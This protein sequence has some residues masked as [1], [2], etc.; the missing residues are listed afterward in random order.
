MIKKEFRN[1]LVVRTDRIGDVVLTTPA[2]VAL[3]EAYLGAKISIL[4]SVE[5][6][7]IVEGN[8][9]LDEILID[10]KKDIHQGFFGFLRL[11]SA[12]K[13]R[14][15]DLAI[16]FHT[17]KRT[18]LLCFLAGIPRR[19]GYKNNK[20]GFLLTDPLKDTRPQGDRHEVEYCLDVL[21]H[22]GI[23]ID[24]P[25]LYMPLKKENEEWVKKLFA[26]NDVLASQKVIAVHSDASC[27]SKRWPTRKF[28]EVINQLMIKH[29]VKIV[30]IGG[31]ATQ[32]IAQEILPA[33]KGPTINL[34]GQASLSQL[35]SLLQKCHL[36]ISNDS[37]PVHIAVAV[38]TPVVS[39]FGRN[40]AGLSPLRWRPLG[41]H[42]IVL[43]KEVGCEV[44]LAHNCIIGFECLEAITVEDVLRAAEDLFKSVSV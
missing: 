3:R 37:G 35:A 9:Y 8:P 22:L 34:V 18:N 6:Q 42:D 26:D 30:L 1:I 29:H 2:I 21:R 36:L 40:Q 32:K 4:V 10:D 23:K 14:Q 19:I 33:L 12:L 11:I 24:K 38:G 13:K 39:I 31:S 5:T 20:F 44:C 28:I 15:F 7:D 43:H 41:A 16:I 25:K 27:I 17:K